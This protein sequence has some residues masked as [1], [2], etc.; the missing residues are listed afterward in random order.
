MKVLFGA[1]GSL[2]GVAMLM[3]CTRTQ[4]TTNLEDSEVI[5]SVSTNNTKADDLNKS[6]TI[7]YTLRPNRDGVYHQRG[8]CPF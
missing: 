6:R 3:S 4:T 7:F 5:D 1:V 8:R 2:I